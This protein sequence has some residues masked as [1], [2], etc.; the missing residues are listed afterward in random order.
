MIDVV[1]LLQKRSN[2]LFS[3]RSRHDRGMDGDSRTVGLKLI[4][5]KRRAVEGPESDPIVR[6]VEK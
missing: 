3:K 4:G 6:S 5:A 2:K 1:Q